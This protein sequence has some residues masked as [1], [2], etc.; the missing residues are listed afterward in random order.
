MELAWINGEVTELAK[1]QC[2]LQDRGYFFGDGIY[3]V[4]RVY[5]GQ[6]FA[7]EYHLERFAKSATAIRLP[8]NHEL[9]LLK[10][11][12]L[13]LL[14]KADIPEAEIYMHLTRG[15]APRQHAFPSGS[16]PVL[17]ITISQVRKIDP[18]I[19]SQ[20]IKA[21]TLPDDRWAHCDIKSLNLLPNILAKQT[22][23]EKG[24]YEAIFIRSDGKVSEGSSSNVFALIA[25]T[26]VTP[27]ADEH[28]LNG[29]TRRLCLELAGKKGFL[30]QERNMDLSELLEAKEIF[31]TSTTMEIIPLINLNGK[32][33][34][35]EKPGSVT[36]TL[37]AE[38]QRLISSLV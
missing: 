13:T 31:I 20:G 27:L 14:E 8:M 26:L 34:S 17:V 5:E 32:S 23:R 28:I 21:I 19:R 30:V 37:Y 7:V 11:L 25:N 22:A 36:K 3:E 2:A 4:I 9:S 29:V 15:I 1:A 10:T 38:Y 16:E 12:I 24:A 6:P 35:D 33:I 18:S